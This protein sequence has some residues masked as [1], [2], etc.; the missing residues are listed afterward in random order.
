MLKKLAGLLVIMVLLTMGYAATQ[1]HY[2]ICTARAAGV[3]VTGLC[4][5]AYAGKVKSMQGESLGDLAMRCAK[6][7]DM[8]IV[9]MPQYG[10]DKLQDSVIVYDQN[11]RGCVQTMEFENQ[12]RCMIVELNAK[13]DETTLQQLEWEAQSVIRGFSSQNVRTYAMVLG[14][15]PNQKMRAL[16]QEVLECANAQTV[17]SMEQDLVASFSGFCGNAE[18]PI[19]EHGQKVDMQVGLRKQKSGGRIHV[20]LGSP[21]IMIS[22]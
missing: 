10:E 22:F 17:S 18:Q 14:E 21:A 8:E 7:L 4:V 15:T 11:G 5:K 13:P 12:N 19:T 16:G 2:L 9:N 3:E 6:S 1:E 20:V